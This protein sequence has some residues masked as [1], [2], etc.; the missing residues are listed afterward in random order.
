M[1]A[2]VTDTNGDF[3]PD[4]T[5]EDFEILEDGKPQEIFSVSELNLAVDKRG[6]P[7]DTGVL[8][9]VVSSSVESIDGMG[10]VYVLILN[11]GGDPERVKGIARQ[12]VEEFLGPTDLMAV[13]HGLRAATQG[14]TNDRESLLAAV[15]GYRGGGAHAIRTIKEVAINLNAVS[16]RRKAILYVGGIGD[17]FERA[18]EREYD[19][20]VRTA[21]RNNVRVYPIDPAGFFVEPDGSLLRPNPKAENAAA[22]RIMAADT[23]G[24]AIANTNNY[25]GNFRHIVRDNSAYYVIAFYSSAEAD[26]R[27]HPV[28][29]RVKGRPGAAVRAR[30][31]HRT[32]TPDVKG[33]SVKLPKNLSPAAR[34]ALRTSSP[35]TGLPL[36]IFTA[37]FQADRYE[38][39]I[40]V[41][42]HLPGSALH[43]APQERIELSY[44][45]VDRWGT[46]RFAERRAF[47]LAFS[48]KYRARV[49]Q[50]GLRLFGRLRLP[51]G[52]YQIRVVAHQPGGASG[53][54]VAEVDVPDY[55][56]VPLSISD[57]VV[58]S[59]HGRTLVTLEEDPVLRATLP[60]QP[61]PSR[62][63]GRHETLT[64]FGE[65]YDSHWILSQEIGVTA[66][67]TSRDGRV[68]LRDEKALSSTNRGRFYYTGRVPLGRFEP[69]TYTLNVE[70]YTRAG[71]PASASQQLRFEVR[72]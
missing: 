32:V 39:S 14:L 18:A 54:A 23:G 66:A 34:D 26:G 48:E 56:D 72:E 57:L 31:G 21:V 64:I 6:R 59:S 63:F 9:P 10:R 38:G 45:A 7:V 37:V 47:T 55:T 33:R 71:V 52:T 16:G 46:V 62:R 15:E 68:V 2:I 41:G 36:E 53:S 69:G 25:G 50:T 30:L 8:A 19:D 13:M 4:L 29:I 43:L 60:A 42:T 65:I 3:V 28:T 67:I 12:F 58:A 20:A 44:V 35:L 5:K 1:D 70:A 51:R 61:D 22:A 24:I 27:L 49:A 40:L 11:G 17:I